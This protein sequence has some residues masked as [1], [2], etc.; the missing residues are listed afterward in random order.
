MSIPIEQPPSSLPADAVEYI[1]RFLI[2]IQ[3]SFEN[4]ELELE[5]LKNRVEELESP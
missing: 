3:G 5:A 4:L 2:Q 1:N